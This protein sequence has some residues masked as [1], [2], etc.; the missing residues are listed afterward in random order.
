MIN[1]LFQK[2]QEIRLGKNPICREC[3]EKVSDIK[4]KAPISIW[5][6][7]NKFADEKYKVLFVGKTARGYDKAEKL[8]S[9]LQKR[10]GEY[11]YI[12]AHGDA[13]CLFNGKKWAYWSY[14]KEIAQRVYCD[15]EY[16]IEH[17][18]LTNLIK[19]NNSST[20]D[21]T[22]KEMK[23]YCLEKLG[24]FW[25]EVKLLRPTHIIFYTH[26]GYDK[27]LEMLPQKIWGSGSGIKTVEIENTKRKVGKKYI[28]WWHQKFTNP[29]GEVEMQILRTS[30]PERKKKAEYVSALVN[31][32]KGHKF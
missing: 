31:W 9:R 5:H 17:I 22:T 18:A 1:T 28:L 14:T 4:N 3:R 2:Y 10:E 24:V 19:C 27:Y 11:E 23:C 21:K 16:S 13:R 30:H 6:V 8:D 15:G 7:G 26:N 32:I 20:T 12:D 25:E 29:N